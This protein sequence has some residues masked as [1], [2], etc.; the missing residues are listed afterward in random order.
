[1]IIMICHKKENSG[2]FKHLSKRDATQHLSEQMRYKLENTTTGWP[3]F[4]SFYF[5]RLQFVII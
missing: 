1:M 2:T 5:P 4:L 3:L